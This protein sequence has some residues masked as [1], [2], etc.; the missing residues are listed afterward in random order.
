MKSHVF[1]S[2]CAGIFYAVAIYHLLVE[3]GQ[4]LPCV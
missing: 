2:F 1:I 4:S 3:I